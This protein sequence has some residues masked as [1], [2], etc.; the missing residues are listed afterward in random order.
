MIELTRLDNT[1]FILNCELIESIEEKPDTTISTISG[2]KYIVR[3]TIEAVVGKVIEYK[4]RI[5]KM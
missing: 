3:E 1:S 5:L 4:S 2:R